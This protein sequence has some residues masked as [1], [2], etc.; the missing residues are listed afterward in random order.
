MA[1]EASGLGWYANEGVICRDHN[2]FTVLGGYR[3]FSKL[4]DT[5]AAIA[6][7][8]NDAGTFW[9]PVVISSDAAA[10]GVYV[11]RADDRLYYNHE[12]T[13][14]GHVWYF[15]DAIGGYGWSGDSSVVSSSYPILQ[16]AYNLGTVEGAIALMAALGL[17]YTKIE[18]YTIHYNANGGTGSM[19]DQV[20]IRNHPDNLDANTFTNEGLAFMG[21][22]TSADGAVVYTDGQE[23]DNLAEDEGEITLYAVWQHGPMSIIIQRN[24]SENNRIGKDITT[25]A[26]LSG[27]LRNETS[28]INPVILLAVNLYDVAGANYLTIPDFGRKY[29]IQDIRSI[30]TGLVEITAH[31]DVLESFKDEIK[32]CRGIM[33]RQ[34]NL[35]NLYLNDGTFR[36]NQN[37]DVVTQPFPSGFTGW[38]FVLAVAGTP[39]S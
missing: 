1:Q 17:T 30:R 14:D 20:M 3:G 19:A 22:A 8:C 38:S 11:S 2:T 13:I 12:Y 39:S 32:A 29:F 18:T 6:N 24:N 25:I 35:W 37:P 23:V 33:H 10:V 9:Y 15:N 31:V 5:P 7:I 21:W 4:T 27:R 36:V 34:E 28:I 16:S 26:T